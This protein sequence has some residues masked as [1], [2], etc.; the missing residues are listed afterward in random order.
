MT[1][2]TDETMATAVAESDIR[3]GQRLYADHINADDP[4]ESRQGWVR[5]TSGYLTTSTSIGVVWEE[6]VL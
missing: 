5:I 1:F 2:Y 6:E 3:T 4:L